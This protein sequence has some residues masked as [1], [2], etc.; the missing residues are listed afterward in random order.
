MVYLR[1]QILKYTIRVPVSAPE[2]DDDIDTMSLS[3]EKP[4]FAGFS[5]FWRFTGSHAKT[6]RGGSGPGKM[7]DFPGLYSFGRKICTPLGRRGCIVFNV[8]AYLHTNRKVLGVTCCY[9]PTSLLSISFNVL[10]SAVFQVVSALIGYPRT[11]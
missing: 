8:R 4:V 7:G 2:R 9:A 6:L 1:L 3:H 11:N 10:P 5:T